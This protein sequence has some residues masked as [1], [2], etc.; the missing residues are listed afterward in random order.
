M[1]AP[2]RFDRIA[3]LLSSAGLSKVIG[4][5]RSFERTPIAAPSFTSSRLE[6]LTVTL[7]SGDLRTLV[8]KLL[9]VTEDW[10]S[11]RTH[12]SVGREAHV[13]DSSELSPVWSIVESPYLACAIEGSAYALLMRDLSSYLFPDVREP[14]PEAQQ[15]ALLSVLARIHARFV[16]SPALELPWLNNPAGVLTVIAPSIASDKEV[17]PL[18]PPTLADWMVRGWEIALNELPSS[19]TRVLTA[20]PEELKPLWAD[21]PV[22]LIHGDAKVANFAELRDGKIAAFDW[23]LT[24]AA[25]SAFEL[26]WYI[27]VNATRIRGTK[28]ALLDRYRE[29]SRQHSG[30]DFDV[31]QWASFRKTAVLAGARIL[32]WRKAVAFVSGGAHEHAEWNWWKE[33]LGRI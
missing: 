13:V 12:D 20:A 22:T 25:P 16:E 8:V 21:L 18:I 10:T 1:T 33:E 29:L 19:I 5:I 27:A 28:D 30:M 11:L 4:P 31:N 7:E 15:E 17:L 6:R 23:T 24:G 26:G 3:D 14:L 32:L 2:V 9:R